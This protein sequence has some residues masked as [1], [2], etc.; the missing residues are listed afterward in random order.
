MSEICCG[1]VSSGH[2]A[3]TFASDI[4]HV[5]SARV[6]AVASRDGE[7]AKRFADAHGIPKAYEGYIAIPHF[8]RAPECSLNVLH[9]TVDTFV[10]DRSGSGFEFQISAVSD[11]ILRGR[12]ESAVVTHAAGIP[13][14]S[15]LA[16]NLVGDVAGTDQSIQT[17]QS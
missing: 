4:K 5:D 17:E 9:E 2:I 12:K 1:I 16:S 11:D 6:D 15:L 10:D 13:N 8:W 7:S 3:G 14:N